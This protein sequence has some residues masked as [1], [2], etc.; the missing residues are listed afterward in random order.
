MDRRTQDTRGQKQD[1]NIPF[2][3]LLLLNRRP[4]LGLFRPNT[5][6]HLREKVVWSFPML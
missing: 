3:S 2:L 5:A 6:P 4:N 1:K